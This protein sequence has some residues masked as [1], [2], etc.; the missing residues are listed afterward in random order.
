MDDCVNLAQYKTKFNLEITSIQKILQDIK[1]GS[2]DNSNNNN[3]IHQLV[4]LK[5]DYMKHIFRIANDIMNIYNCQQI[6][7]ITTKALLESLKKNYKNIINYY[8]TPELALM[9][10]DNDIKT[11]NLLINNQNNTKTSYYRNYILFKNFY[12]NQLNKN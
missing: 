11:V 4:Q 5:I 6:Y 1:N 3:Y 9:C 2:N 8:E 7:F 10:I 12:E